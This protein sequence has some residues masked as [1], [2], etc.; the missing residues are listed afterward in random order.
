MVVPSN[1]AM[2]LAQHHDSTGAQSALRHVAGISVQEWLT[3]GY[4]AFASAM[5]LE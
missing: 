1:D 5:G 3:Q 2:T 4:F